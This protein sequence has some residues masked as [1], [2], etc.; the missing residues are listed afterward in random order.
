MSGFSR[1]TNGPP[2]GGHY[3]MS[4]PISRQLLIVTTELFA[5]GGVQR[6]GREVVGALADG[7]A[8][9]EVWSLLDRDSSA[10]AN[11]Y[12]AAGSRV[13]L[14]LRALA[15]AIASCRD[16]RVVVMHVHLAPI[17]LPMLLRGAQ[18]SVFV[19]GVEAWR[20]LPPIERWVV[21]RCDRVIAISHYTARRF[22]QANPWCDARRVEV[23]WLGVSAAPLVP[24]A[25]LEPLLVLMVSRMSREDRYKGHELLIRAWSEVRTRVPQAELVLIG[26][27][28]DRS[29]LE[30][31]A[32][33]AGVAG[34]VRFLGSVG[35][36]ELAAWY[37]R[38]SIF[39]LPSEG[40]GF[41]LV[42]LEA[43]RAGKA[44]VTGPG[45][46][47]EV[48]EDGV[49]GFVVS[50]QEPQ[51]LTD[52]V[53]RL[54][55]DG[56]LRDRLGRAGRTR[57]EQTFTSRHFADRLR[58]LLLLPPLSERTAPAATPSRGQVNPRRGVSV[59]SR[60]GWGPRRQ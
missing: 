8:P 5:P 7:T 13:R 20:A 15:R 29:R 34:A 9:P 36:E 57:F 22:R 3:I 2:K 53:L 55:E 56:D 27:G 10:H 39:V 42:L 40:E 16:L 38:C 49:T 32:S 14:G 60:R 47:A 17:A 35:E 33:E 51:P 12:L 24:L 46:P 37:R 26:D 28:D 43:M 52:A 48:V 23:C 41:G 19:N 59:S 18:V 4:T 6:L 58:Q 30:A 1:T 31:I 25:P 11:L 45:A 54:L 50:L 44:C 21:E